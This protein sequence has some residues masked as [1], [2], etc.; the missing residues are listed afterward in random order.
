M[1][2]VGEGVGQE[3]ADEQIRRLGLGGRAATVGWVD[4]PLQFTAR[5][6]AFVLASD[7][8]GFAQV[9]TEAMS[10]GCPVISTDALGGGPRYITDDGHYG[11]LIP[12]GDGPALTEAMRGALQ[13]GVRARYSALGLKRIEALTP[14]A[15]ADTLTKFLVKQLGVTASRNASSRGNANLGLKDG[16]SKRGLYL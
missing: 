10:T 9:L 11:I 16:I 5:A 15:C 14:A 13:P 12:R 1:L 6:C 7:E 2:I 8:E 3:Q 4:D